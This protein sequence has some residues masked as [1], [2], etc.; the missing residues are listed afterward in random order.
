MAKVDIRSVVGSFANSVYPAFSYANYKTGAYDG[1]RPRD[2]IVY[3]NLATEE[4]A[5][6]IKSGRKIKI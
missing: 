4:E 3:A 2:F 5:L 1:T 6:I